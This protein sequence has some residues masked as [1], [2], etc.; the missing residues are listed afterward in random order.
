MAP[1]EN[2]GRQEVTEEILFRTIRDQRRIE[3]EALRLSKQA[4]RAVSQRP[5]R[6]MPLPR[7][8]PDLGVI[9]TSDP[10]LPT[11]PLEIVHD[12]RGG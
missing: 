9:D 10:N 7:D 4:R 5:N 12:P 6:P 11:F 2:Q 1:F 3:D 8:V